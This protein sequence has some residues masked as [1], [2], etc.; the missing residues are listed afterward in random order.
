MKQL[1]L[2]VMSFF[3]VVQAFGQKNYVQMADSD[4]KRN[5]EAWMIDF[6]K[7]LKWNYCH[8]L[9]MQSILQVSNKMDDPK[10]DNYVYDYAD[11]MVNADGTIKTYKPLEYNIDRVN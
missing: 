7:A 6:S 3:I 8:G 1:I 4:M 2:L 11:T 9:V 5:P 10:Y